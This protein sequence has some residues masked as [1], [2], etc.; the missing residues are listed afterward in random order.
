MTAIKPQILRLLGTVVLFAIAMGLRL[1]AVNTTEIDSPIRADAT[2]YYAYALNLK[3]YQTFAGGKYSADAVPRPDA[4]RPPGYPVFLAPLVEYP[5]TD[6]MLWRISL[7][8]ALLDSISVIL[9][10]GIFRRFMGEGW[11]LGAAFLTAISPHLIISCTYMLTETLFTFLMMLSLWLIVKMY[12]DNSRTFAVAAGIAIAAAALTRPTLQFF[13]IPLIGMLLVSRD[14]SRKT[15]LV[16]GLL[17]GFVLMFSP[18]ALRNLET[19]GSI[20]DPTQSILS[21]QH[22]MYP[23]FRYQDIPESAGLPYRFDPRTEEITRNR[24]S[25]IKEITRRFKEEP[26]RYL[27][28]YLLGKPATLLDW[29]IL[30]GMGDV[31]V[32]PVLASPYFS[33]PVYT[34]THRFMKLLHWPLVILALAAAVLAWLPGFGKSLSG[35][36]LFTV[37][38]LSLLLLYFIALHIV[39][40]PYPRYS[41][42]LRPAIYGLALLLCSQLV[43]RT[44]IVIGRKSLEPGAQ[45][46]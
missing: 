18:W 4:I 7:I 6:F 15:G 2:E 32:Y 3:H 36:A 37:R 25:I 42:P 5:P 35:P 10:L 28:W 24:A 22:G 34:V 27:Q 20:A 13:I 19:I 46:G 33:Q 43:A 44:R 1:G 39:V 38:L 16:I 31:F 21:L 12:Q 9:A 17:A 29:N 23:D 8:Q 45:A 11:A 14:R 26:A 40:A 30:M 41:I